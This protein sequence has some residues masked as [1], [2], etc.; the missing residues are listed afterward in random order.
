MHLVLGELRSV[1]LVVQY[2]IYNHLLEQLSVLLVYL[3]VNLTLVCFGIPPLQLA[4]RQAQLLRR[5]V[6][7]DYAF[8]T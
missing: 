8:I 7:V 5:D 2:S 3:F 1:V 6:P 4:L